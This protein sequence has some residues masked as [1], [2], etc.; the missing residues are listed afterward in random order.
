MRKVVSLLLFFYAVSMAAQE[1]IH[2]Y[3][4]KLNGKIAFELVYGYYGERCAG[5][6]YYPNAK[7]PAPILIVGEST[8]KTFV[9]RGL[10]STS[11]MAR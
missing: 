10:R 6:M 8:P 5:Y 1:E 9:T 11:L 4:G 2:Y 7:N 3:K